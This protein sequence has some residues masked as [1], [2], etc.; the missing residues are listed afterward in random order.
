MFLYA[1]LGKPACASPSTAFVVSSDEESD[2]GIAS[3]CFARG[4]V[5]PRL[6]VGG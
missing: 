1:G 5:P 4:M 3:G 2:E 6:S